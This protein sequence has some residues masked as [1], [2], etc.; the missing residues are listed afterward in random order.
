MPPPDRESLEVRFDLRVDRANRLIHVTL[1]GVPSPED[2]SWIAEEV[3][4]AIL[5]F[6]PDAGRH[7]T[8]YDA[9]GVTVLPQATTDMALRNLRGDSPTLWAN[10]LAF[11]AATV[12]TR[13]QVRRIAEARPGAAV[14]EDVDTALAWLLRDD[15]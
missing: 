3:R 4:A 2:I 14:F 8:L 10:R 12:L 9:R 15:D 5:S 11:V 6:G 1:G 7:R 13:R